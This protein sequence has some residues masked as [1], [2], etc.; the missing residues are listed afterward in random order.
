MKSPL[1][2][3]IIATITVLIT[4]L[5]PSASAQGQGGGAGGAATNDRRNWSLPAIQEYWAKTGVG[6]QGRHKVHRS[7]DG[8][9]GQE[10][11]EDVEPGSAMQ[12]AIP[13]AVP[14]SEFGG[15]EDGTKGPGDCKWYYEGVV[16]AAQ[17]TLP[18]P[19][20]GSA[21]QIR[22][23]SPRGLTGRRITDTAAYAA[24]AAVSAD[25]VANILNPETQARIAQASMQAQDTT[26]GNAF[27]EVTQNQAVGAIEYCQSYLH[28]FTVDGSNRWNKLRDQIFVPI[29]VLLLLPGAVL[30]QVKAI[31]A[32][33]NPILGQVNPL[34]GIVR[35]IV[36]IFLIPGTYLVIN[37]GIDVANAITFAIN[38]EYTRQFG[39][40]MYKDAICGEIRAF[41]SRQPSE[42]RNAYDLPTAPMGTVMVGPQTPF[43]RLEAKLYA[44]KIEDPCAGVYLAP[45]DR[46]DE[47]LPAS[48]VAARLAV[49]ASNMALCTSWNVLCAFQMAYLYYLWCVGPIAA[50]L[51][52]WPMKQLRDA[53]PSWI[54]GALTLCF[55]SLFWNTTI[56]LMACFRGVDE[57]GTVTMSALNFL[58]TA[59]VKSAFDFS[60]LIRSAG[61]QASSMAE[62]AMKAAKG[63]GGA[64]GAAGGPGRSGASGNTGNNPPRKEGQNVPQPPSAAPGSA[65]G[66]SQPQPP[67]TVNMPAYSPSPV[68]PSRPTG[69]PDWRPDDI[70]PPPSSEDPAKDDDDDKKDP[71]KQPRV[72]GANTPGRPEGGPPTSEPKRQP[73]AMTLPPFANPPAAVNPQERQQQTRPAQTPTP[74]SKPAA[75]PSAN[76]ASNPAAKPAY[77]PVAQQGS[78]PQKPVN[79]YIAALQARGFAQPGTAQH[80]R[81]GARQPV[82]D[83]TPPPASQAA[84]ET[85]ARE[86]APAADAAP[87]IEASPAPEAAPVLKPYEPS[88]NALSR[89]VAPVHTYEEPQSAPLMVTA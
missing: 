17:V 82:S 68:A 7:L 64:G 67:T 66:G 16:P 81:P 24:M 26:T 37:Y 58:A 2:L 40:D 49:G 25:E 57:T 14:C 73:V 12:R 70:P 28:N 6:M 48:A 39:T 38:E 30:A 61:A 4:A 22:A 20:R 75:N 51:W 35:S 18:T 3:T 5:A 56:L 50:A 83:F 84:T 46:A 86:A 9:R 74:S 52:V 65:G 41:P 19:S 62:Q 23:N 31:V 15:D 10:Q 21:A 1:Q 87:P 54:E 55:W 29:A 69:A 77:A 59:C 13:E 44:N 85:Y 79:P 80:G 32:A 72:P 34:D 88:F 53:L 27:A 43:A 8:A 78:A 47:A 76:P 36:A 11:Y 89:S 60:G 42:N 63:G 33:G 45:P 71:R